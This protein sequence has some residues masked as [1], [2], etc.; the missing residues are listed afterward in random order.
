MNPDQF[1]Q[2]LTLAKRGYTHNRHEQSPEQTAW[3]YEFKTRKGE[4]IYHA[5]Y[6]WKGTTLD[7]TE[8][9]IEGKHVYWALAYEGNALAIEDIT[10]ITQL[11]QQVLE[12]LL[13]EPYFTEQ[14]WRT[15]CDRLTTTIDHTTYTYEE[16]VIGYHNNIRVNSRMKRENT[17]IYTARCDAWRVERLQTQPD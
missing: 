13:Q 5:D 8:K 1:R 7:G 9:V 12:K 17:T 10:T 6:S 4:K 3:Q 15:G 16:R 11:Q 14:P 2:F